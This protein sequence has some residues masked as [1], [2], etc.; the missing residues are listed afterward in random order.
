[1][2]AQ[3]QPGADDGPVRQGRAARAAGQGGGEAEERGQ[4][5]A[6]GGGAHG[7]RAPGRG[8][9]HPAGKKGDRLRS[10][11]FGGLRPYRRTSNASAS[12][13]FLP[14]PAPSHAA[15]WSPTRWAVEAKRWST[16]SRP[17]FLRAAPRALLA[18]GG[19]SSGPPLQPPS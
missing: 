14:W 2:V 7:G 16:P 4:Q 19:T 13:P 11:S 5:V 3:V 9:G 18:A 17:S 1:P 12:L 10:S 8:G 6:A 15:S